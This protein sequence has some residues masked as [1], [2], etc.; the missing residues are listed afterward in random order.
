M[1]ISAF[2]RR[3]KGVFLSQPVLKQKKLFEVA[4]NLGCWLELLIIIRGLRRSRYAA[5]FATLDQVFIGA[6][7]NPAAPSTSFYL[8]SC[9]YSISVQFVFLVEY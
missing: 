5:H 9:N 4:A 2:F 6:I 3:R 7:C 8:Q 1:E